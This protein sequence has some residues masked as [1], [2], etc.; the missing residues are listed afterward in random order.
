MEHCGATSKLGEV[1]V[2]TEVDCGCPAMMG[3]HGE[4][5][6]KAS[7]SEMSFAAVLCRSWY[8]VAHGQLL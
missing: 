8:R 4:A 3:H 1:P 2:G 6:R 5:R 7:A